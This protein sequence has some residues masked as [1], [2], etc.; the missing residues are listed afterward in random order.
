M[1]QEPVS[2]NALK[3][4]VDVLLRAENSGADASDGVWNQVE[5]LARRTIRQVEHLKRPHDVD[6][7]DWTKASEC[8]N[9]AAHSIATKDSAGIDVMHVLGFLPIVADTME[10]AIDKMTSSW[11]MKAL[12]KALQY[13]FEYSLAIHPFWITHDVLE[14]VSP[15]EI[16]QFLQALIDGKDADPMWHQPQT[17]ECEEICVRMFYL[18]VVY[19]VSGTMEPEWSPEDVYEPCDFSQ[20]GENALMDAFSETFTLYGEQDT[21]FQMYDVGLAQQV[22]NETK[23]RRD[24]REIDTR[25]EMIKASVSAHE[26]PE[27]EVKIEIQ[28]TWAAG[29]GDSI[30]A[31]EAPVIRFSVQARN[32]EEKVWERMQMQVHVDPVEPETWSETLQHLLAI[33]FR[34]G[35]PHV[36]ILQVGGPQAI[37]QWAHV[38]APTQLM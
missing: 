34:V 31:G 36:Q 6:A 29:L 25:L 5:E 19:T 20:K 11:R 35:W 13:K 14:S 32:L 28:L 17:M 38:N 9:Y 26:K 7:S 33:C 15:K 37:Q 23:T 10:G 18:P 8:F 21:R 4:F 1:S 22:M 27:H 2:N 24:L 3:E 30:E 12:S 16:Q